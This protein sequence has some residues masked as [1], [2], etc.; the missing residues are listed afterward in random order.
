M[1]FEKVAANFS[2]SKHPISMNSLK[3]SRWTDCKSFP[4]PLDFLRYLERGAVVKA[5]S[6]FKLSSSISE[7]QRDTLTRIQFKTAAYLRRLAQPLRCFV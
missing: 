2:V 3:Y 6:S 4:I 5:P 7:A 1:A